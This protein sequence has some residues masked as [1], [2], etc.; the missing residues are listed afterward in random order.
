MRCPK[1]KML[2]VQLSA[3]RFQCPLCPY[4]VDMQKHL[5]GIRRAVKEKIDK[6]KL[7]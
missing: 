3:H 4:K 5:K 2:M 7:N 6:A 1:C